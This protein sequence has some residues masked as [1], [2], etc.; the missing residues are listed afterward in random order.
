MRDLPSLLLTVV[1]YSIQDGAVTVFWGLSDADVDEEVMF[2]QEDD[3]DN[4]RWILIP[5]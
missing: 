1:S 3:E 4:Q 5:A 2:G